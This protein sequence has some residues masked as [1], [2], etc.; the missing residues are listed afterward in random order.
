MTKEYK[1]R[2]VEDDVIARNDIANSPIKESVTYHRI[3]FKFVDMLDIC[4]LISL[5]YLT[6]KI[7][8]WIFG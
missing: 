3:I 1:R 5:G 8:N 6:I 2:Y 7:L 4:L